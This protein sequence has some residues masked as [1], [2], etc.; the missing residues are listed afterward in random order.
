MICEYLEVIIDGYI[1]KLL[2]N[3]LFGCIKLLIMNVFWF[4]WEWG[5]WKML[6]FCYFIVFYSEMLII[7]DN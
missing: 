6:W 4:F 1:I 3:V 7:C 2:I 5:L